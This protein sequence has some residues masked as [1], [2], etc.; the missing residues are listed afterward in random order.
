[1]PS[2]KE[3]KLLLIC[4]PDTTPAQATT[5]R[6]TGHGMDVL[7]PQFLTAA[8]DLGKLPCTV[9][10]V[11]TRSANPHYKNLQQMH[12]KLKAAGLHNVALVNQLDTDLKIGF[13]EMQAFAMRVEQNFH[14]YV[15]SYQMQPELKQ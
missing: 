9:G 12:A 5:Y 13:A 1:M 7:T 10:I 6:D 4:V 8:R 14:A 11:Y 3:Y 2:P 15:D